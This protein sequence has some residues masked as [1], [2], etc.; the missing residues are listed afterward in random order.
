MNRL[1]IK[2]IG[3]IM[4]FSESDRNIYLAVSILGSIVVSAALILFAAGFGGGGFYFSISISAVVVF[5]PILSFLILYEIMARASKG[6]KYEF[7]R[8][9]ILIFFCTS[10]ALVFY[11]ILFPERKIG[12]PFGKLAFPALFSYFPGEMTW[13]YCRFFMRR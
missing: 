11:V 5:V 12:L 10:L 3:E 2:K 7:S 1:L 8:T 6:D 13:F 9:K 4:S